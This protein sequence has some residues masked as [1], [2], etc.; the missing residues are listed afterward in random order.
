[1]DFPTT[2]AAV[3]EFLRGPAAVPKFLLIHPFYTA[4]KGQQCRHIKTVRKTR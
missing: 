1:M 2:A 4:I 3:Y